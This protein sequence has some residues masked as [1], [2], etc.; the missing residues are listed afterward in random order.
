MT[1]STV[2]LVREEKNEKFN[3]KVSRKFLLII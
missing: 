3:M 1:I 2:G